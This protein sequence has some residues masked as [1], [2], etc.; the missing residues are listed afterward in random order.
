MSGSTNRVA[1]IGAA[2]KFV[3]ADRQEALVRSIW[4]GLEDRTPNPV[5]REISASFSGICNFVP[6]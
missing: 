4:L 2:D 5:Q 3:V 6:A 1:S